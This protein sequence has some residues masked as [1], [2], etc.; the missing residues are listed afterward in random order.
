MKTF[1]NIRAARRFANG[2]QVSPPQVGFQ[3]VNGFE[4]R[5]AFTQPFGQARPGKRLFYYY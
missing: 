3:G 4:L 2:M 5:L 1:V